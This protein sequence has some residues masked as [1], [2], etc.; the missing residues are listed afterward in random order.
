MGSKIKVTSDSEAG[1]VV[2]QN[3][4]DWTN[5]QQLQAPNKRL[6]NSNYFGR[7]VFL[8]YPNIGSEFEGLIESDKENLHSANSIYSD[9]SPNIC[10]SYR[11]YSKFPSNIISPQKL[12]VSSSVLPRKGDDQVGDMPESTPTA[13]PTPPVND[14]DI[15]EIAEDTTKKRL[16]E[17]AIATNLLLKALIVNCPLY[18]GKF[19]LRISYISFNLEAL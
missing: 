14:I 10:T 18:L 19:I 3:N 6:H 1:I 11:S 17:I 8:L 5:Q 9:S 4:P 13:M 16:T 2:H 12:V 15:I 7:E